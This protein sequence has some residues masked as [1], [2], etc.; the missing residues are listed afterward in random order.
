L[1]LDINFLKSLKEGGI[2]V[3]KKPQSWSKN[4]PKPEETI[5]PKPKSTYITVKKRCSGDKWGIQSKLQ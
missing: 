2:G 1:K 3:Y 4:H 5:Y